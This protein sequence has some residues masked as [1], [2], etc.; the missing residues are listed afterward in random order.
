MPLIC[1]RCGGDIESQQPHA[2]AS[3]TMLPCPYCSA[4]LYFQEGFCL[5]HEVLSVLLD[6]TE[7]KGILRRWFREHQFPLPPIEDTQLKYIPFWFTTDQNGER[8]KTLAAALPSGAPSPSLADGHREPITPD[9]AGKKG[10]PSPSISLD[11]VSQGKS[12][13]EALLIWAPFYWITYKADKKPA[14]AWVDAVLGQIS[15]N[16]PIISSSK[17]P[18]I[19]NLNLWGF[20]IL[21]FCSLSAFIAIYFSPRILLSLIITLI[22]A[23]GGGLAIYQWGREK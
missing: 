12:I 16:P 3:G 10:W 14:G 19:L 20:G 9:T 22:I 8:H 13:Q 4:T 23:A 7:A 18:D 15:L 17:L 6:P 21:G 5:S 11:K 2:P 1:P